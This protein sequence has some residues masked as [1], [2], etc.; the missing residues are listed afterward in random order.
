VA[1]WFT[2]SEFDVCVALPAGEFYKE[3]DGRSTALPFGGAD[4]LL[5]LGRLA[6]AVSVAGDRA[7]S[8]SARRNPQAVSARSGDDPA[9]TLPAARH[10]LRSDSG[11]PHAMLALAEIELVRARSFV[12][13]AAHLYIEVCVNKLWAMNDQNIGSEAR[14]CAR[15]SLKLKLF[16]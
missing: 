9:R 3:D 6:R 8:R 12:R 13:L 1:E 11:I 14:G 4:F 10:S 2:L 15:G 5:L 16:Q 7:L